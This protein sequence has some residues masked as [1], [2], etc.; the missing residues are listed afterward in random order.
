MP[1]HR[2][3]FPSIPGKTPREQFENLARLLITTP[4]AALEEKKRR[5]RRKRAAAVVGLL[6]LLFGGCLG[7]ARKQIAP[8]SW[9]K[10]EDGTPATKADTDVCRPYLASTS[11]EN[12]DAHLA[13]FRE[14]MRD[15]G[16]KMK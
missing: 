16:F 14:C 3:K 7:S 6:A 4:P 5:K 2:M 13:V 12:L 10:V 9:I 15:H 1:A 8:D 11:L